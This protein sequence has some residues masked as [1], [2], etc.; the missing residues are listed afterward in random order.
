[1]VLVLLTTAL[2]YTHYLSLLLLPAEGLFVLSQV[3]HGRD[4]VIKW[5]A[6]IACA[7]LLFVPGL[8]LLLHNMTFDRVRNTSRPEPAPIVRLLPNLIGELSIGQR[9]LGFDDPQVRRATLAAAAIIFPVLFALGVVAGFRQNRDA[10][11]LLLLVSLVPLAIYIGSGRRLVA[12]RFFLPFMAGYLALLGCGLASLRTRAV[13]A[14]AG[15]A[16]VVVCA[17][18]LW[19][20]FTAFEWSYDHRRVA[21]AIAASSRPGDIILVVHPYEAL[22][23]RWYLGDRVPAAGMVFTALEDQKEYVIKPPA[24]ELA[25]AR[26]RIEA[27]A[28]T[29]PRMWV[30]GQSPRSFSSDAREQARVL[31]WMDGAYD[32]VADLGNLTGNDPVVRLYAVRNRAGAPGH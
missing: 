16:L 1:V 7:L 32:R 4:R 29:H 22:Y 5:T 3:R 15:V 14:A 19:H 28:A 18:P 21:Q 23:Y 6:A 24:V 11:L 17:I 10:T 13:R 25:R 12:V 30:I 20:F 26:A 27:A 31:A 2:L 9:I 8:P